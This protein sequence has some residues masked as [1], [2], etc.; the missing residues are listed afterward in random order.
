[1]PRLER[2]AGR[3]TFSADLGDGQIGL[4]FQNPAWQGGD[5]KDIEAL[6]MHIL[7]KHRMMGIEVHAALLRAGPQPTY[8]SA[9]AGETLE[10]FLA[11]MMV[12]M[13]VA[14]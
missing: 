14:I 9:S 2:S 3:G 6:T 7:I 4:Q 10:A 1:M 5:V 8:L 11:G 12:Q 13:I